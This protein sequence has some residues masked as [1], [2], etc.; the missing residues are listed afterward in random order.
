[1][2]RQRTA[3]K[4]SERSGEMHTKPKKTKKT[5]TLKM[6]RKKALVAVCQAT[7]HKEPK[8]GGEKKLA[9]SP[10]TGRREINNRGP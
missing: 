4:V 6:G 3:L 2:C 5:K 10:Q 1:M 8:S 7:R 9:I